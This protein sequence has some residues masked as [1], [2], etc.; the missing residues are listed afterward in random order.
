MRY[1]SSGTG[2]GSVPTLI[3]L[4]RKRWSR[5][6]KSERDGKRR[7][8]TK[9]KDAKDERKREKDRGKGREKEKGARER[10]KE[11]ARDGERRKE[12][13][14]E[15]INRRSCTRWPINCAAQPRGYQDCYV[16]HSCEKLDRWKYLKARQIRVANGHIREYVG[17]PTNCEAVVKIMDIASI[18]RAIAKCKRESTSSFFLL[19]IYLKE[20]KVAF[21]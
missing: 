8:G 14:R 21:H 16:S 19:I 9:K 3:Q 17:P 5:W 15:K 13:R 12:K 4:D 10:E 20:H 11:I 7:N 1:R 18:R 6:K 2:K